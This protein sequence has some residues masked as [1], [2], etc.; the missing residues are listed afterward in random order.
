[1]N[2]TEKDLNANYK[3]WET[4]WEKGEVPGKVPDDC[5]KPGMRREGRTQRAREKYNK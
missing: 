1:M 5:K 3:T 2:L 4:R